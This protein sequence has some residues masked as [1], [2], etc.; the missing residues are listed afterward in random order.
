MSYSIPG[1][2]NALDSSFAGG[3]LLLNPDTANAAALQAAI[4]TAL[5]QGGGIVIIP[6]TDA[7]LATGHYPMTTVTIGGSGP[8]N[9][10]LICGTGM[11]TTLRVATN[12]DL[13]DITDIDYVNF[14]DLNIIYD[15][16]GTFVTGTAF[17]FTNNQFHG[18]FRVRI[19]DCQ[20]PV[21]FDGTDQSYMLECEILYGSYPDDQP[22]IAV[23][24]SDAAEPQILQCLIHYKTGVSNSYNT[25]AIAITE[26]SDIRI[27]DTQLEDFHTG[28]SVSTTDHANGLA[29]ADV[30]IAGV[31]NCVN[32][33]SNTYNASFVGCHFQ[34]S[35]FYSGPSSGILLGTSGDPNHQIDTVRFDSCS[36]T[37]FA[38]GGNGLEIAAGRNICV[39]GGYYAGN[40]NA[41]IAITGTPSEVQIDGASC[42]G[43]DQ[44]GTPQL[45]GISI[46]GGNDIQI[47][48]ANC[49]GNGI[50]STGAGISIDGEAS[51]VR[52]VGCTCVGAVFGGSS[53][54]QYGVSIAGGAS[55][56]YVDACTLSDSI[57]Y[58]LNVDAVTDV[59]VSNSDL[60]GNPYGLAVTGSCENV[61]VSTCNFNGNST[62]PLY[63]ST[64]GTLQILDSPGY[65]DQNFTSTSAPASSA[66]FTNITFGYY[67]PIIFYTTSSATSTISNILVNGSTTHLTS[68]SFMIGAAA[69][70][71]SGYTGHNAEIVYFPVGTHPNFLAVGY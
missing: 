62:A 20:Y 38:N 40:G 31:V 71:G 65:N 21:I 25:T 18:L 59:F 46:L 42:V 49:S 19:Q 29:V 1:I 17:N 55:S 3:M 13:F 34:A 64:P 51:D 61:Y 48:G 2:Y 4:D 57:V 37:G 32:L 44:G 36:V 54:Q 50:E 66:T 14:Q 15:Q 63:T 33:Q 60:S 12:G 6:A 26:S 35:T 11:G 56:T 45:Y 30:H 23:Q 69:P 27:T 47:I 67:G 16:S 7:T 5:S 24:L 43:P 9:P 53:A 68:G 10:L 58:G 8:D 28:I 70:N 39:T 22:A 52:I 41:G